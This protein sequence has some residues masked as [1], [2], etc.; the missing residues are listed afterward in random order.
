[1]LF[2]TADA[3]GGEWDFFVSYAQADRAWAEWIAWQ[4][5]EAEHQVLVQAW[6]MVPGS[7]WMYRMDQGRRAR[8]AVETCREFTA[9]VSV[10]NRRS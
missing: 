8:R 5:E 3:P 4:L 6:D 10:R 2:V 1:V 9:D 7:N